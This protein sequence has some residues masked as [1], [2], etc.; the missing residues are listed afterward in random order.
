[1]AKERQGERSDITSAPN[2]A[3][4]ERW[5]VRLAKEAGIGAGSMFRL[6]E[7]KRKRQD[8]YAKVFDGSYSI[9][10]AHGGN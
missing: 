5:E 2:G 7:V 8:L 1:M 6:I 9:G 3:K 4:V 10:T